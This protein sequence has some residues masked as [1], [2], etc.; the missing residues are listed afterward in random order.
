MR[1][2]GQ[3]KCPNA[4]IWCRFASF[5][6][7]LTSMEGIPVAVNVL[8]QL[9]WRVLGLPQ[10]WVIDVKIAA[11]PL[12]APPPSG[13]STNVHPSRWRCEL[14]RRCLGRAS[15]TPLQG[16]AG[17]LASTIGSQVIRGT[18]PTDFPVAIS[19]RRGSSD[20]ERAGGL[21]LEYAGNGGDPHG[22][23]ALTHYSEG[24]SL[25]GF[26]PA[27]KGAALAACGRHCCI[28][29][30]FCGTKDEAVAF[31]PATPTFLECSRTGVFSVPTFAFFAVPT[32]QGGW[33]W[34]PDSP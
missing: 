20:G 13:S 17:C 8:S 3:P 10:G 29:H 5:K 6:A 2:S 34:K 11:T 18:R 26:S 9:R 33:H 15:S 32:V 25:V 14:L 28:C 22:R 1:L 31:S 7:L 19:T 21:V 23:P 12:S 4:M 24:A 30:R 16:W 27:V